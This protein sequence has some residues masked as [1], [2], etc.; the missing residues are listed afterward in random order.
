MAT[1]LEVSYFNT[2]WVK[3]LKNLTQYQDREGDGSVANQLGGTTTSTPD[4]TTGAGYVNSNVFEDWFVEESRIQGGFNNTSVDL[5][6][7]HI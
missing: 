5:S 7:I 6:L 1:T 2:F 4:P 3:R